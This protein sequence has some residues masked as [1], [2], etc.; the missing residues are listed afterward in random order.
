MYFNR[1]CC[2]KKD[3]VRWRGQGKDRREIKDFPRDTKESGT[4][5]LPRT[6]E[7]LHASGGQ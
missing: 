3:T 1:A 4:G 6:W 5:F 7:A 2:D